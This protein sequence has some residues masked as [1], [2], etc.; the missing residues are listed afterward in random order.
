MTIVLYIVTAVLS[1]AAA[2]SLARVAQGPSMLDR[3]MALDVL[4]AVIMAGLGTA[5]VADGDTWVLPTLLALSLL[6]FVGSVAVARFL[7]HHVPRPDEPDQGA[8]A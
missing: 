1:L 8:D 7:T 4:L 3:A 6:A 2:C 5:A